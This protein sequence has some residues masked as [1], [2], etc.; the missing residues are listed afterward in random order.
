MAASVQPTTVYRYRYP[1]ARYKRPILWHYVNAKIDEAIRLR[2]KLL[3]TA[4]S[5]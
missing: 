4:S 3:V 1:F 2:D 5:R